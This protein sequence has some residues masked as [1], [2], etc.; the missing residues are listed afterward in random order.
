[1]VRL[2]NG[3][4]ASLLF[5][6]S[7]RT[8]TPISTPQMADATLPASTENLAMDQTTELTHPNSYDLQEIQTWF[9]AQET[10][11]DLQNLEDHQAQ[12]L[13]IGDRSRNKKDL[14]LSAHALRGELKINPQLYHWCF[15]SMLARLEHQ[16]ESQS[17]GKSYQDRL[18]Q[19]LRENKALYILAQALDRQLQNR[20][21][22]KNLQQ[23]YMR[24]SQSYFG[25]NLAPHH[26]EIDEESSEESADFSPSP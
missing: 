1:M 21:Y 18:Q 19:F 6:L 22:S 15:Y 8:T 2:K 17:L 9:A 16:L 23:Q 4:W 3:F 7:C 14:Q 20:H 11:I 26:T 10:G 12:I 5:S 13:A 24:L 25:R